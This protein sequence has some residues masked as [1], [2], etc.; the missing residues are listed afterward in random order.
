MKTQDNTGTSSSHPLPV[1][2]KRSSWLAG[3]GA[4]LV[5]ALVVG[6][7]IVVFAQLSSRHKNAG[8]LTPPA[9]AWVEVLKG[10]TITQLV[11]V[12]NDPSILYACA[13]QSTASSNNNPSYTILRST[14]TGAHWQDVGSKAILGESCQLAVNP[15]DSHDIYAIGALKSGQSTGVLKHSTD[16][17][18]AW[19][20]ITPTLKVPDI[21]SALAWNAQQITVEGNSLFGVQW[22][23]QGG[24]PQIVRPDLPQGRLL[25][26]LITS[27][28]GGHT[29]TA[30]D[31]HLP[32]QNQGVRDYAVDPSHTGT[33]YE[34]VG[35]PWLPIDQGVRQPNGGSVPFFAGSG[36]LY[37]TTDNGATWKPI[38][39]NLSLGTQIHLASGKTQIIYVGG[40]IS[41]LP[42]LPKVPTYDPIGSFRLQESLDSGATWHD[43][44]Q[45]PQPTFGQNWAVSSD[46]QVYV[47]LESICSGTLCD[48]PTATT[49]TIVPST[50]QAVRNIPK[51]GLS[52]P[53]RPQLTPPT[54]FTPT[55]TVSASIQHYDPTIKQWRKLTNLPTNGT[56]LTV[57]PADAHGGAILWFISVNNGQEVLN[58]Y[59]V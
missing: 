39:K 35:S 1:R 58:R 53:L 2:P 37:K 8:T 41:R 5:V 13:T 45:L 50:P 4:L 57:T 9:G 54:V 49:G 52:V 47:Y 32:V 16:G 15:A 43:V 7:S 22:L 17:G 19:T 33:I 25:S 6:M 42:Y 21:G 51:S 3:I 44:P 24:L 46:G 38:L 20:T 11:A 10:Y 12:R 14:D 55:P 28:D 36:D 26:R 23:H 56:L 27:V 30:L 48:Q 34:L 40:A 29:W 18:Q 31:N 59:V